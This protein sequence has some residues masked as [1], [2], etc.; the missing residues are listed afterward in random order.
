MSVDYS[1][2]NEEYVFYKEILITQKALYFFPIIKIKIFLIHP[3][4][5]FIILNNLH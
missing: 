5:L 3:H 2:Q 1:Q 4:N